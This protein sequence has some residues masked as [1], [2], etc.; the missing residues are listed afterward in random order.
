M[1][2]LEQL[3]TLAVRYR[4]IVRQEFDLDA[5]LRRRP[6]ILLV[7]ELAHSNLSGGDPEP[8][9]PKRW[10]DVEELLD[11]GIDVWTT[12]NIQHLESLND[13]VAQ[14]TG[15][16]QRETLP[17]R[18]FDE[19]D[20][21]ELIDLPPDD[22][23]AR[24]QAGK[25]YVPDE[26]GTAVE[27]FFRKPNLMA[28]RELALRRMADRV[29][30]ARAARGPDPGSR[31]W[32]ARDRI[33]VAIGPDEQAEQVMRAGKRLADALDAEWS[34][35][36]VET[37]A[38]LQLSEGERNRRIDLLRL[39]ESLGAETVTLDGPTA[40]EALH[41]YAQTRNATRVVVGASKR[42]GWRAWFRPS[43]TTELVRRRG[44]ST[45]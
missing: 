38:L 4:D 20:E 28:L 12:V 37:P 44:A 15:V 5:A 24:L 41:E 30:V 1:E 31:P 21:V 16:R 13:V 25:V 14:I 45:S 36:Y 43:T 40:A 6:A 29:D 17:D 10:Q 33:L 18:I 39:A 9:H 35:V 2:G 11:A 42:R 22:L 23:I 34:A 32:L 27:R 3:P 26:I 7:D 8:R 19:A